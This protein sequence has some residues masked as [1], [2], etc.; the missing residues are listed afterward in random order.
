[1]EKGLRHSCWPQKWD[2]VGRTGAAGGSSHC[3]RRWHDACGH[4][5]AS[6]QAGAMNC[7]LHGGPFCFLPSLSGVPGTSP[8]VR[9][10][11]RVPISR[12]QH[13]QLG[14]LSPGLFLLVHLRTRHPGKED[15]LTLL[16]PREVPLPD[17]RRV[18]E[19]TKRA[20][21]QAP[22]PADPW[23][24]STVPG[25]KV[26]PIRHIPAGGGIGSPVTDRETEA[27]QRSRRVH[28][29]M[30][31]S[32]SKPRP[33]HFLGVRHGVSP[34]TLEAICPSDTCLLFK[35]APGV[36]GAL[37]AQTNLILISNPS[38]VKLSLYR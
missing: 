20:E 29:H 23:A 25:L 22:G 14:P 32:L 8:E 21:S 4:P 27:Q 30:T 11:T 28:C 9:L 15:T 37:G 2:T 10:V 35:G 24:F 1:M 5:R 3:A 17:S 13:T 7:C 38:E 6:A 33:H 26:K 18:P 12:T 16:M 31:S 34:C 19:L 36:P